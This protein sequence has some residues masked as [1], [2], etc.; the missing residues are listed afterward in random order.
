MIKTG[1]WTTFDLVKYLV[2][3]QSTLSPQEVERLRQT[4]AFPKEGAEKEQSA[5]GTSRKVKRHRAMDLYEPIDTFRELGLPVMD[6]GAD[7]RWRPTSDE[8]KL[9]WWVAVE[10]LID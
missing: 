1:D 7:N 2:S 8:G 10:G 5:A 4:S 6:W 3:I 9:L